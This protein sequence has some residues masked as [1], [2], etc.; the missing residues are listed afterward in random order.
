[1]DEPAASIVGFLRGIGIAVGRGRHRPGPCLHEG[2]YRGHSP[3]LLRSFAFGVPPGLHHLEEAG[4]AFGP[5]R[6]KENG[7][8]SYPHMVRWLR[9]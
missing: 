3:G 8:E 4:M 1:M 9:E 6:A 2:G 7:V 5:L